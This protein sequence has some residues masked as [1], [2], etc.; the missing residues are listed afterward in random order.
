M[1]FWMP[2]AHK[3]FLKIKQLFT[4]AP[5]IQPDPNNQFIVAVLLIQGWGQCYLSLLALIITCIAFSPA[6][7][8]PQNETKTSEIGNCWP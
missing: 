7:C 1:F 4:G 2:E 3:A 6:V 5:L 8:P